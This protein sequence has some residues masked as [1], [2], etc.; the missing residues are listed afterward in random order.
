MGQVNNIWLKLKNSQGLK[1]ARTVL[2][3][4]LFSEANQEN[5]ELSGDWVLLSKSSLEVRYFS[6][7]RNENSK[8]VWVRAIGKKSIMVKEWGVVN[9]ILELL[10]NHGESSVSW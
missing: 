2:N 4:W 6:L 9:D 1:E 5:G 8:Q 10:Y 7:V 3:W